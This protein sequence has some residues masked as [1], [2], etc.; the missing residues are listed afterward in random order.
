[1][2]EI[3]QNCPMEKRKTINKMQENFSQKKGGF[4][5]IEV[6]IAMFL[7]SL[8]TVMVSGIFVNF[9]KNYAD[10]RKMQKNAESVQFAMNLM[11]KTIRTSNVMLKNSSLEIYDY[12]Q[13][14]CLEYSYNPSAKRIQMSYS[15][16]LDPGSFSD[17]NFDSMGEVQ[18]ITSAD[19]VGTSVDVIPSTSDTAGLVRMV[20]IVS[21]K[22]QVTTPLRIQT[23]VS[24]RN[25]Q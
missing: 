16:D 23:T 22:N 7:F 8:I 2:K 17:C 24:L 11:A 25:L 6:L 21:E 18:D 19:I 4:T 5:L 12:A 15:N 10:V 14:R 20:F 13:G 3:Y 1:M 9:L